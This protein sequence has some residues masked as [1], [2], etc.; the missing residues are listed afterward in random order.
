M[1]RNAFDGIATDSVVLKL[2]QIAGNLQP[3]GL[4]F[5]PATG[6]L[7]CNVVSGTVA[8]SSLPTVAAVTTV[9]TVTTTTTVGTLTNQTNI[10]GLSATAMVVDSFNTAWATAVRGLIKT[11]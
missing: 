9:T 7:R 2:G 1:L 8:V 11:T 4:A 5:D 10:G 6:L 3:L